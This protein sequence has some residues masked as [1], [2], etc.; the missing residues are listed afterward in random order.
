[1]VRDLG[2]NSINTKS[3][4]FIKLNYRWKWYGVPGV[5]FCVT[6]IWYGILAQ[7]DHAFLWNV[8]DTDKIVLNSI[9]ATFDIYATTNIKWS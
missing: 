6:Y 2:R 9:E 1:M 8:T 3:M 4:K 7:Y 5:R